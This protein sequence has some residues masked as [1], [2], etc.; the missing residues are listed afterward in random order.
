V[1]VGRESLVHSTRRPRA[2]CA[3][4]LD[5]A[6]GTWATPWPALGSGTQRRGW[7][8]SRPGCVPAVDPE[9]GKD[10]RPSIVAVADA[11]AHNINRRWE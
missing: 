3:N 9:G 10:R 11:S 2:E 5:S 7:G 6:A 4:D 1:I 8:R